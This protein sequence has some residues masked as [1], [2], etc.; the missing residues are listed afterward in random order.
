MARRL[1]E[2]ATLCHV[3][4]KCYNAV[5]DPDRLEER[6][7]GTAYL[8][9]MAEAVDDPVTHWWALY[10]RFVAAMQTTNCPEADRCLEAMRRQASDLRQPRLMW[11]SLFCEAG[12]RLMAGQ[13]EEVQHLMHD[14]LRFAQATGEPD[15][16]LMSGALHF[17][18][19]FQQGRASELV[20]GMEKRAESPAVPVM[21]RCLLALLYSELNREK[22]ASVLLQ[23]LLPVLRRLGLEPSR[24]A[25]ISTA[26]VVSCH[27][28]DRDMALEFHE[29]LGPYSQQFVG[30][31]TMWLGSVDH[32]LGMLETELGRWDDAQRHFQAAELTHLR[33][34]ALPCLAQTRLQWAR[35]LL[36]SRG[37]A[38]QAR[39]L[40]RHSLATARELGLLNVERRAAALL[41]E[42]S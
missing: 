31:P 22:E 10:C 14:G 21:T 18:L 9:A 11:L 41:T 2:P 16:Y 20:E 26:A 28:A 37:D 7:S 19:R 24:L 35:M 40:L 1:N 27:L 33:M 34:A 42:C 6:D 3:L 32:F 36:G 12:R 25:A 8:L 39:E 5:W 23:N 30:Y 13:F 4:V 15:A 17:Q 38:Q 29:M